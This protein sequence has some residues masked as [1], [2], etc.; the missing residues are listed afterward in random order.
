MTGPSPPKVI[1]LLMIID[2]YVYGY[3][4]YTNMP[5]PENEL[6]IILV[7]CYFKQR[8]HTRNCEL[9]TSGETVRLSFKQHGVVYIV[10]TSSTNKI[11]IRCTP[12]AGYS[13]VY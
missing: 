1:C 7:R 9:N 13:R 6:R 4:V 8:K 5:T 10:C 11:Q 12:R 3:I 2:N